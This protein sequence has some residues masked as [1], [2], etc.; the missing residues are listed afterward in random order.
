[1]A[2]NSELTDAA[3]DAFA[4]CVDPLPDPLVVLELGAC[5]G[6]HTEL[7]AGHLAG[8]DFRYYAFE[9]VPELSAQ[10]AAR[11]PEGVQVIRAAIGATDGEADLWRSSGRDYYGS[12]SLHEPGLVYE[13]LPG[14][15]F[16]RMTVTVRRLDTFARAARLDHVDFIWADIQGAEAGLIEGGRETLKNTHWLYTEAD[17]N[18]LYAGDVNEAQITDLLP[19][20]Q[21]MGR[22]ADSVLF[23]NRTFRNL[24]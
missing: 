13:Q 1:M 9:P 23:R 22:V 11:A 4:A 2:S 16:D 5:D 20:F 24:A 17:G 7:L 19:S 10:V 3:L 6:Y 12:S 15:R 8:R 14:V 21:N 18:G